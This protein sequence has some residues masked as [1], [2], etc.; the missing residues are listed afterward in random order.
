MSYF[1]DLSV[2][3]DL[4]GLRQ[5]WQ[6]LEQESDCSYFQ[7][8]GW[9]GT[10][11]QEVV[12]DLRCEVIRVYD[13]KTLVAV[14]VLAKTTVHR[15]GR[16]DSRK[17]FLNEVPADNRNMVIEYNGLLVKRGYER[18][19]Y[20]DVIYHLRYAS[21]DW[22][23]LY[24]GMMR[25]SIT[26]TFIN[27]LD[28]EFYLTVDRQTTSWQYDCS[29][30]TR[31]IEDIYAG[32]SRNRRYQIKKAF[33]AYRQFGE[34]TIAEAATESQA[35][36]FF[37]GLKVLHTRRWE[38]KGK[39][40]SFSNPVWE[41]YH[42]ALIRER[43]ERGE[44]QLLKI[45]TPEKEI[46]YIYS[47]IWRK[48]VYVL[49]TGFN[50]AIPKN[51]Q[52]GYVSHLLAIEHNWKKGN[53]LYDLLSEDSGYKRT[54]C[55]RSEELVSVSFKRIAIKS[56]IRQLSL[57]SLRSGY[58][59]KVIRCTAVDKI[60]I[61]GPGTVD[62]LREKW[63]RAVN[64]WPCEDKK[65]L[66]VGAESSGTTAVSDLLFKEIDNIRYLEEGE[67]QWVWDAY[68]KIYQGKASIRDYPRLQLFD[69][70]KVPGFSMI[71]GEFREQFPN[72]T[73]VYLIRDPRD[74][75][76]SAIKT[77]NIGSMDEFY[78]VPWT[79]V[80]WLQA[81]CL[82]PV[83]CLAYRWKS[84]VNAASRQADIH[85]IKYEDFCQD[86][87]GVIGQLCETLKLPFNRERVAQLCDVQLSHASVRAYRPSGPG[88]WRDSILEE[89][90][91]RRIEQV[92]EEEMLRWGY[93]PACLDTPAAGES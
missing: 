90:H 41:K 71:I 85:Y 39:S 14:G 68:R 7:S 70:I 23:E 15:V 87:V 54:L 47:F 28:D 89:K 73:V 43:F 82:D 27:Q 37:D 61:Y 52:P 32:L 16:L 51:G 78:K 72:T 49:Q 17:L 93:T 69:A 84:Y 24:L 55:N 79:R 59:S 3:S 18:N 77:W 5:D 26:D 19:I 44:I 60:N 53:L 66:L 8:W 81:E 80:D 91:I 31:G 45:A 30:M 36:Q 74:F 21:S 88:G 1:L 34:I 75:A 56:M 62:Y 38:D 48:R 46:G 50:M 83:E 92:C 65:Y 42:R 35:Q 76:S 86:K 58:V 29:E 4:D 2:I 10:W 12:N 67:Q 25:K 64:H 33:A 9:I 13:K 40:G 57:S 20:K 22:D 11:L 6:Q 63:I